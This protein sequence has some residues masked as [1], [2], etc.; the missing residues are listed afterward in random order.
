MGVLG[1]VGGGF[2]ERRFEDLVNL[3]YIDAVGK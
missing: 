2:E 1:W 3:I